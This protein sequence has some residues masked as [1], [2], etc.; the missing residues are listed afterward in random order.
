MSSYPTKD[1][2]PNAQ[3]HPGESWPTFP[4]TSSFNPTIRIKMLTESITFGIC[5]QIKFSLKTDLSFLTIPSI[6]EEF[7]RSKLIS[8]IIIMVRSLKVKI[9]MD[10]IWKYPSKVTTGK[11]S[12]AQ[13]RLSK[14]SFSIIKIRIFLKN[15]QTIK[16]KRLSIWH[17][18]RASSFTTAKH[19]QPNWQRTISKW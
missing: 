9:G 6:M 16:I 17:K 19:A 8:K 18:L 5:R 10:M 13:D 1:S 12:K 14:L 3:N 7:H 2:C 11:I 4:I 15:A